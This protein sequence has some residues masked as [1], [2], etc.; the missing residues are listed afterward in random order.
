MSEVI[1]A[2]YLELEGRSTESV[3]EALDPGESGFAVLGDGLYGPQISHATKFPQGGDPTM[4]HIPTIEGMRDNAAS[5]RTLLQIP[6]NGAQ[7]PA[8][9][10]DNN[11]AK[12][13]PVVLSGVIYVSKIDNNNS[14]PPSADWQ[15]FSSFAD[16]IKAIFDALTP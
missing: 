3:D 8:W 12:N 7:L 5:F 10:A 1:D 9:V 14:V 16:L 13:Y 6:I 11:Y 4:V 2:I 15:T